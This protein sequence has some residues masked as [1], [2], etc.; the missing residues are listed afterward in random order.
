MNAN[1]RLWIGLGALLV[2]SFSVLLWVGTEIHRVMPPIPAQVVSD[3]RRGDLHARR[4]REGPAG[5]AV[6]RRPA[7][8][9][10]L[11]TRQLRRAGLERRLAASRGAGL[12]GSSTRARDM[13]LRY[14]ELGADAAGRRGR[15][16]H[17]AHAPQHL[18]RGHRH[19]DA[20]RRARRRRS[21]AVAAHYEALFGDD[22]A[23]HDA[24]QGLRHEGTTRCPTRTIAAR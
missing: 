8:R 4:H 1:R 16:P 7:A 15:A 19:H 18:R 20:R 11:G 6:H 21:R 13:A 12:A 22:P 24:A 9:L 2:V 17:A 3:E 14:A 5:L 23:L 10:D